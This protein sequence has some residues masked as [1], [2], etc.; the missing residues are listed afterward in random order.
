MLLSPDRRLHEM[1]TF[2]RGVTF[3]LA[4]LSG[5]SALLFAALHCGVTMR[6]EWNDAMLQTCDPGFASELRITLRLLDLEGYH[7][8]IG[9]SWRSIQSQWLAF[10]AGTSSV[11]TSLHNH[12]DSD[13][14]KSSLAADVQ[15]DYSSSPINALT[16]LR[17]ARS[18][19]LTT[20]ALWGLPESTRALLI[21]W[22]LK[23]KVPNDLKVGWDRYHVEPLQH[24][25][26]ED[27]ATSHQQ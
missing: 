15:D 14:R 22:N 17:C 25:S 4:S 12:T 7:P 9:E 5:G 19:G 26:Q 13:G 1:I 3:S 11:R 20:G 2:N 21:S 18:Q 10:A 27:D 24:T 6:R 23:S 8:R 16:L